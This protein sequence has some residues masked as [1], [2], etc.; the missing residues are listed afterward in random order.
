MTKK[1]SSFRYVVPAGRRA[2][3]YEEITLHTQW[4]PKNFAVQ[5]WF[6]VDKNGRPI[7]NE[8]ATQVRV[9]DWWA[10]RD[11]AAEWFRPF[12]KRQADIGRGIE[13]A[14]A[15]AKRAQLFSEFDPNWVRFLGTHYAAFRYVDYGLFLAL[16]QAQREAGSD[17]VAQPIVYQSI[18]KDRHAQDVTL[19]CAELEGQ[20]EGFSDK[21]CKQVWL[22]APEWQPLRRVIE[23]LLAARDWVEIS[24]VVNLLLDPIVT[25]LFQ[26]EL[27]LRSAPLNGDPVTPV[28]VEGSESDREIRRASTTA[29]VEL[30]LGQNPD[31]KTI[32]E[33][34]IA[35][36]RPGIEAAAK[37]LEPLFEG[38]YRIAQPFERAYDRVCKDQSLL[39]RSLGLL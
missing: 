3:Q 26:R 19:Y 11:P 21:G 39:M 28:L 9:T 29:F 33:S 22:E 10:Y 5:G 20:I 36:W 24:L 8:D 38:E 16:C 30:M 15:G 1:A 27:V 31:N 32:I 23:K 34:W 13:Q 7:W 6:N 4:D 18:E 12:V 17:V 14:I 2:T 37:G 35:Q 25:S